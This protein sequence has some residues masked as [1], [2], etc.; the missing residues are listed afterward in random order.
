MRLSH[1]AHM[2]GDRQ[3]AAVG[4]I[5]HAN[6]LGDAGQPRY[7]GL[8]VV[9]RAGVEKCSESLGSLQLFTER[10]GDAGLPGQFRVS[11]HIVIPERLLE[12]EDVE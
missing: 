7:I 6:E 8:G 9:D 12:P 2:G 3:P 10:D 11:A 4:G 1:V 5:R